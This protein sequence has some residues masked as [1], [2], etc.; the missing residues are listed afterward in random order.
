MQ[1]EV[2]G[3]RH[4]VEFLDLL[5]ILLVSDFSVLVLETIKSLFE[6]V[7]QALSVILLRFSERSKLL[8]THPFFDLYDV[9]IA[10]T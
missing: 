3:P 10:E 7:F 8:Q 9:S 5:A 1:F 4:L 2:L 6:S